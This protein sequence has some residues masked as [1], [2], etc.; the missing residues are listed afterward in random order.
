MELSR[1]ANLDSAITTWVEGGQNGVGNGITG[2]AG[3]FTHAPPRQ[4]LP[5]ASG[6][7]TEARDTTAMTSLFPAAHTHTGSR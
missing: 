6:L 7:T 3:W 4:R 1:L 2:S 5:S